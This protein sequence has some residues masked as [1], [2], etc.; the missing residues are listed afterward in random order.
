MREKDIHT[1]R[2]KLTHLRYLKITMRVQRAHVGVILLDC[3]GRGSSVFA[4]LYWH[5]HWLTLESRFCYCCFFV[6]YINQRA[7]SGA[8]SSDASRM[9]NAAS[10]RV[11]LREQEPESQRVREVTD[12]AFNYCLLCFCLCQS[13]TQLSY[14]HKAELLLLY[15]LLLYPCRRY[16]NLVVKCATTLRR[17]TLHIYN[18]LFQIVAIAMI[19][20]KLTF[21]IKCL[22]V[23]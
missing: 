7:S 8:W 13:D 9:T 6:D 23:W 16:S 22:V 4:K 19:I 10:E 5:S 14:W 15:C 18:N 11:G 3:R 2:C 20:L 1:H 17:H 21:I 12:A